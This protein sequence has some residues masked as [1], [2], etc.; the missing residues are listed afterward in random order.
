MLILIQSR[1]F[2]VIGSFIAV[3]TTVSHYTLSWVTKIQ[4]SCLCHP[5]SALCY[6]YV[7]FAAI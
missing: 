1:N 2:S 4:I 3:F 6:C 5:L 7:T